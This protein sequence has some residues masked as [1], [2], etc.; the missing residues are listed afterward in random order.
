[1]KRRHDQTSREEIERAVG[2]LSDESQEELASIGSMPEGV[3]EAALQLLP[4]GTRASL[5]ALGLVSADP[6]NAY[7]VRSLKV[8][9][10]GAAV[11]RYLAH[12]K[13]EEEEIQGWLEV[14]DAALERATE[15]T[16]SEVG[17][18]SPLSRVR[19][20]LDTA[21]APSLQ[22]MATRRLT[23]NQLKQRR[24]I[25]VL[26]AIEG[27]SNVVAHLTLTVDD[28][29][30][31]V[32]KDSGDV[33][34]VELPTLRRVSEVGDEVVIRIPTEDPPDEKGPFGALSSRLAAIGGD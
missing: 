4:M 26:V 9:P 24:E 33:E 18:D 29:A 6:P 16:S 22:G 19:L 8:L 3:G 11:L 28:D 2:A 14:A 32:S 1:M 17:S 13:P 30:V 25:P 20:Q 27:S 7:G 34:F 21:A 23:W 10:L 5:E 31:T 15:M 12:D